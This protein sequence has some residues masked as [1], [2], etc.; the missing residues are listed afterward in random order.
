MAIY[1]NAQGSHG[2]F[3]AIVAERD[4]Y[5]DLTE[6]RTAWEQASEPKTWHLL[7][8]ADHFYVTRED[9]VANWTADWLE[10]AL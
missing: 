4:Q 5:F 1:D 10:T 7:K 3:A 2:P 8:W 9:E 6:T